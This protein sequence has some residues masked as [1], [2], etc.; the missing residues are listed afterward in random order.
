MENIEFIV[1]YNGKGYKFDYGVEAYIFHNGLFND[2]HTKY[3]MTTLLKYVSFVFECYM[4]DINQTPV[5]AF[6][7]Y[8]AENWKR[9][10][11]KSRYDVLDEFYSRGDY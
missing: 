7:D 1:K 5:G 2:M 10:K 11:N 3:S 6:A 9:V 8:V 4:K